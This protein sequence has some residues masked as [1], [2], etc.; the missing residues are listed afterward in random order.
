MIK[1]VSIKEKGKSNK[2]SHWRT[3]L[4]SVSFLTLAF[5]DLLAG[6]AASLGC[7]SS[8]SSDSLSWSV[9]RQE[10][11]FG[12]SVSHS[13]LRD[14]TRSSIDAAP[15]VTAWEK[16]ELLRS[17]R[18]IFLSTVIWPSARQ[19]QTQHS[20][21]VNTMLET[22]T[23]CCC[24]ESSSVWSV[25][26]VLVCVSHCTTENDCFPSLIFDH[27]IGIKAAISLRA[28][29]AWQ[30]QAEK[31]LTKVFRKKIEYI[32]FIR[33]ICEDAH[34]QKDSWKVQNKSC[35]TGSYLTYYYVL[36]STI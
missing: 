13:S 10:D 33:L 7:V 20:P 16:Y 15:S 25:W 36:F 26:T 29:C 24:K 9:A 3:F 1:T 4:I 18:Q 21:N 23:C 35:M 34:T 19:I 22:S 27:K 31:I 2:R 32:K 5:S 17:W 14:S 8:T 6:T 11:F 28:S 30:K 12:V